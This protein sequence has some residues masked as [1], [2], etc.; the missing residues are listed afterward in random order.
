MTRKET[1]KE[2]LRNPLAWK[3]LAILGVCTIL[4]I[5]SK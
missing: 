3:I 5:I 1:L 2:A 4:L